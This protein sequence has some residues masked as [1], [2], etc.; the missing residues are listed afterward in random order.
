M[1]KLIGS[2][3]DL[4][5]PLVRLK[6]P[7]GQDDLLAIIDTGF[8]GEL[9]MS[10]SV[11]RSLAMPLENDLVPIELGTGTIERVYVGQLDVRWL[12]QEQ[13]LRVLVSK[14]WPAP[15]PDAPVAL[16]GTRL[17]RPHLLMIDF[18]AD[19]LEIETQA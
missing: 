14:T 2:I 16:I 9:M 4:G 13:R 17:L 3:D 1:A 5:R 15:R 19:T 12:E 8:N 6:L 11:A 18:G 7:R 10:L